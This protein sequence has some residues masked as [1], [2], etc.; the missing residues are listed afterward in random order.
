MAE[1]AEAALAAEAAGVQAYFDD[2]L[3]GS[4]LH[5]EG[6]FALWR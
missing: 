3:A 1:G 4:R 6:A 2:D 5:L